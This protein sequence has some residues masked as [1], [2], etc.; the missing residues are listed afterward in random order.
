[1]TPRQLG[2]GGLHE[3][4]TCRRDLSIEGAVSSFEGSLNRFGDYGQGSNCPSLQLQSC[5]SQTYHLNPV[6]E[7]PNG[8]FCPSKGISA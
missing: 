1:M 7:P 8:L 4:Q 3:P 6:C 5:S 2:V